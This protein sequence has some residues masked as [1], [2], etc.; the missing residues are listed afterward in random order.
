MMLYLYV[1]QH[2]WIVMTLLIGVALVLITCLTY[3]AMWQPRGVEEKSEVIKVKGPK[4]FVAWIKSFLPWVVL[5][6]ILISVAF[7]IATL[8][9]KS[10]K[11]PNW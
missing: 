6:V 3:Q 7:T 8:V 4:S 1:Q 2:Q 11:P 5:L 10:G 9:A